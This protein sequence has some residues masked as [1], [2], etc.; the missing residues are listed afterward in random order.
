[1][2]E[3][4]NQKE[5]MR[6][7]IVDDM[8][9]T[10]T[11][12]GRA[13]S[14]I[15]EEIRKDG[16]Q[17]A[18][19]ASPEDAR[20][21]YSGLSW[22]DC[23]LV[24]WNVGGCSAKR[25]K[26]TQ[27]L[28]QQIREIN[29]KIP[30]FL[31]GE[32]TNAAPVELTMEMVK[33]INEYI[34]VMEDTPEF[35]AGRISAAAR[36]YREHLLPPFFGELVKFSKDFEYS[37]HTPGHAGG[38]AFLKSPAG[39]VFHSFF[40]EQLF[41]SDL[42][43]SVGELGSLLDH[44]GPVGE[45]ERYAAKVFGADQTY[46]VTNG[47]STANKI[48]FFGSVTKDDIVL[49]DRN[50]HKSS[51]HALTMTHSVAVYLMPTRNR[52][53]IIGPIPPSEMTPTAIRAKTA[54][55]PLTKGLEETKP[56]HVIIT[57]STYDGLCYHA[58]DV[59]TL[60][61][62][63]VDSIHF[64]EAW[65]AYARFNPLYR[66][67]FAMRDGAKD[68]KGPTVFATQSTH[69]LLAALSQA[70]MVHVRNGRIPIEH[71][72]FNEGFMMH[73]ST[74]PLYTII[75]SLD[76]ST[77]MMDGAP[78]RVLTTDSIEEAIRFRR[79]MARVK[80]EIEGQG[81]G[82]SK[83]W[84]FGM[85]QPETVTDPKT[86]KKILFQ[87]APIDLLRETP[88]AWVLH[89]GE[90]WH[91]FSGLPDNY[92]MLDPIKVTVLMPGVNDDG[93]LADWGIPAAIVVKFLDTRGIVN[94]KSGDYSI[95]F[96]FSMGITKG[97]WGTLVTE[98]F[99]FKRL[100]T[101]NAPL[102]E[103]FPDLTT[104]CPDRYAGKTLQDLVREMH[105]FKKENR[106]CELLGEAYATLPEP[107]RTYADTFAK[108]VKNKVEY[109]P[110]E[111]SGG[112]IVAT[113]IVPYPPGIPLLAPGEKTGKLS[114]PVL[115]YLIVLQNF[116]NTFPGFSHDIHGI[117]NVNGKYMMYCLKEPESKKVKHL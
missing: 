107:A 24:N 117:E 7:A 75:A 114:G 68:E 40:G 84:W 10:D 43:I 19:V 42:S 76:I 31:M 105:E 45:A 18:S 98:L 35:I 101:E 77:K 30:I 2:T 25:H 46:F 59:E 96:L 47:T 44:S 13:I 28:I 86:K 103:I 78:G 87:D 97:K 53:G 8:H 81:K 52:Y 90:K 58:K 21:A 3:N 116:D 37:W 17:I 88:S 57:N 85:W 69:K 29:E 113:G 64:D 6:V 33:E 39:R 65:Y 110:V 14:R 20:A 61:G 51:E 16:I 5:Q 11:P 27:R 115:Q 106:M 109:I 79:T 62:K 82:K 67:R 70:S 63:S 108:L 60:L 32:P 1:M 15:M 4:L 100:Y 41:R 48:V 9:A 55:C 23:I 94:E 104:G 66:D 22:V 36:R 38:I 102:E 83:D 95:L 99:E 73:S 49:V 111:Q 112:R 72:R 91:G 92:C 89:P 93:S 50:C 54:A 56:V 26:D 34:W 71:S 12:Q 74:S 80:C